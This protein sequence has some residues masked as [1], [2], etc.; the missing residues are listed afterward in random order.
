MCHKNAANLNK[1]LF[2][3]WEAADRGDRCRYVEV[4]VVKKKI[5]EMPKFIG[6][7]LGSKFIYFQ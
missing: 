1:G 3:Y 2:N 5:G 4:S 7:S 6:F